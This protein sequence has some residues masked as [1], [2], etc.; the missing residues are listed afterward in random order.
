M[1]A[2]SKAPPG[3]GVP[4]AGRGPVLDGPLDLNASPGRVSSSI[5]QG[6]QEGE[7]SES[8]R[9]VARLRLYEQ[10]TARL[11]EYVIAHGLRTGD[12]LPPEVSSPTGYGSAVPRSGRPS[13]PSRCRASSRY[14]MAGATTCSVNGPKSN[15]WSISWPANADSRNLGVPWTPRRRSP[16]R[17]QRSAAPPTISPLSVPPWPRCGPRSTTGSSVS[18]RTTV[19][20]GRHRGGAQRS[21]RRLHGPHRAGDRREPARAISAVVRNLEL[22]ADRDVIVGG[23]QAILRGPIAG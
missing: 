11:R 3:G 20:R 21:T 2:R 19:P 23:A 9:P 7:V 1:G 15:R 5:L 18:P 10:V 13:W 12:R 16:P 17:S 22:G 14:G 4:R 6:R 8:L